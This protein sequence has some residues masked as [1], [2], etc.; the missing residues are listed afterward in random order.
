MSEEAN[1]KG[2][3]VQYLTLDAAPMSLKG[4]R[5]QYMGEDN[6]PAH[7]RRINGQ[8]L[9]ID[10]KPIHLGSLRVQYTSD[11]SNPASIRRVTGQYLMVDRSPAFVG[12]VRAQYLTVAKPPLNI[13]SLR[14]QFL[15]LDAKPINAG[16]VRAQFVEDIE[17]P[18]SVRRVVGHVMIRNRNPLPIRAIRA[19]F[20]EVDNNLNRYDFDPKLRLLLSI[21]NSNGLLLNEEDIVFGNPFPAKVPNKWNSQVE[22]EALE[23]SKFSGK[24]IVYFQRYPI[25]KMFTSRASALDLEGHVGTHDL[26][27][28]INESFLTRLTVDD[29]EDSPI[30][31]EANE[32]TVKVI[33]EGWFFLKGSEHTQANNIGFR[34]LYPVVDLDGFIAPNSDPVESIVD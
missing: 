5:L 1:L 9:M 17:S 34:V 29:V 27:P 23:S 11:Q 30:N 31:H 32:Y 21:N 8:Y 4:T 14:A 10:R 22:I 28:Q 15:S 19:Q 7:I 18:V 26:L 3:R 13:A 33:S 12:S 20:A 6:N 24:M 25:S 2:I 16:A